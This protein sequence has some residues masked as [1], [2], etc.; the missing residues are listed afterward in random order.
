MMVCRLGVF[1]LAASWSIAVFA[2]DGQKVMSVDGTAGET[3]T[4]QP[5]SQRAAAVLPAVKT[6]RFG[7]V[8]GCQILPAFMRKQNI[9]ENAQ[10]STSTPGLLGFNILMHDPK[11]GRVRPLV[12][13]TWM[14]AGNLG[15]FT[16]DRKGN[17]YLVPIP[18]VSLEVNPPE[19]QNK[20]HVIDLTTALMRELIDLPSPRPIDT[21]NPFGTVG[22]AYDCETNSLYVSSLAGSGPSEEMG[23]IFQIN[24]DNLQVQSRLDGIDALGVGVFIGESGK[25][26]YYGSARRGE[27]HSIALGQAGDFMGKSR[28]EFNLDAH[29]LPR[30]YRAQKIS[31]KGNRKMQI[32]ALPFAYSLRII[33]GKDI[34]RLVFSYVLGDRWENS[35]QN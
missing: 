25:R 27:V 2:V 17:I 8:T 16:Y 18:L 19:N 30:N 7:N 34:D 14:S 1:L 15:Q 24:L 11:A 23:T 9:P 29:G 33:E 35:Q 3:G 21:S 5:W 28:F 4:I 26:L 13:D 31:F 32:K 12:H 22:L 6:K 20:V 10:V